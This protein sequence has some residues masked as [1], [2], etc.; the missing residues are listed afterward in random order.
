MMPQP[1]DGP[2]VLR[3]VKTTGCVNR[4]FACS[5]LPVLESFPPALIS[6]SPADLLFC[7]LYSGC[8]GLGGGRF[9]QVLCSEMSLIGKVCCVISEAGRLGNPSPFQVIFLP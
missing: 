5:Q 4:K 2:R 1:C 8:C 7:T 9:P 6:H 3:T